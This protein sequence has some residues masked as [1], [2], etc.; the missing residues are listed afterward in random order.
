MT[1]KIFSHDENEL[2]G[3]KERAAFYDK[4]SGRWQNDPQLGESVS[5]EEFFANMDNKPDENFSAEAFKWYSRAAESGDP[6]SM[7]EVGHRLYD[8][9]GTPKDA[10][11]AFGWYKRAA[12]AGLISAMKVVAHMLSMG[13]GC[14]K[15][16]SES[17][18]WYKSAADAGNQD[19]ACEVVKCLATGCG[20]DKNISAADEWL[21]RLDDEHYRSALHSLCHGANNLMWIERLVAVNDPVGLNFMAEEHCAGWYVEQNFSEALKYFI[22]AGTGTS[23]RY[24]KEFYAEALCRAGNILYIGEGNVEPNPAQAFEWYNRA[25]NL[26]YAKA[27]MQCG[28]MCYRGI[29][30]RQNFRRALR[31]FEAAAELSDQGRSFALE[32]IGRMLERGEFVDK[33]IS[34]AYRFYEAAARDSR[35]QEIIFKLAEDYFYGRNVERDIYK[36]IHYYEAASEYPSYEYFFEARSRLAWIYELG[37]FVERDLAK[38]DEY[39]NELPPECKPARD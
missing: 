10:V 17:F 12:D 9:I 31:Y 22:A 18:R 35:N 33:N 1:E 29:G 2:A 3:M 23:P 38:A 24:D 5:I 34:E 25:A 15:N 37:Q 16:E 8:G 19:A 20:V 36:A 21:A 27:C 14:D 11:A 7:A 32:C 4:K 39:W 13:L 30:V 28:L 26:D 6:E